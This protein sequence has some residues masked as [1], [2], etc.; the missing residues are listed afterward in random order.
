MERAPMTPQWLTQA[1]QDPR[2][3]DLCLNGSH[4]I[5]ADR[6]NGL[7]PVA[8]PTSASE[9]W[10]PDEMRAWVLEQVSLAGKTWDARFPF[11]DATLPSGHRLHVAFPPLARA[12]R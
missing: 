8:L 2:V 1:L 4:Q 6:G 3:T 7:E 12:G 9:S 11:I 5:F 10:L